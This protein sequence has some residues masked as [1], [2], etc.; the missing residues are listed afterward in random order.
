MNITF[1]ELPTTDGGSFS[2][3]DLLGAWTVLYFYPKD[4]TP[5]C[6]LEAQAF[7]DNFARFEACGARIYGVSRDKMASHEKFKEKQ[8]LPFPLISDE[9][10]LLCAAFDV[11]KPKSMFGKQFLGVERSTFLINPKGELAH[12]WRRVKVR[13]HVEEVLQT[14]QKLQ[15]DCAE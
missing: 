6:T 3:D 7:R 13:G 5:G 9:S 8:C 4:A 1:P 14:L 10:E 12:S 15:K 2:R 11:I